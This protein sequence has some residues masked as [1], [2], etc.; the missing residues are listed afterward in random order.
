MAGQSA[1][2]VCPAAEG[3]AGCFSALPCEV[4]TASLRA[5]QGKRDSRPLPPAARRPRRRRKRRRVA[6]RLRLA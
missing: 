1:S 3:A 5:C 2:D 6:W 4:P